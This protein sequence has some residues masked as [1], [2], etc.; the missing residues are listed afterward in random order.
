MI[1]IYTKHCFEVAIHKSRA[2]ALTKALRALDERYTPLLRAVFSAVPGGVRTLEHENSLLREWLPERQRRDRVLEA[3]TPKDDRDTI[4]FVALRDI[5]SLRTPFG[6][7]LSRKGAG[8]LIV[9]GFA[10]TAG[11]RAG[12]DSFRQSLSNSLAKH[13]GLKQEPRIASIGLGNSTFEHLSTK[14]NNTPD[15]PEDLAPALE[16][17]SDSQFRNTVIRARQAKDPTLENIAKSTGLD[18]AVVRRIVAKAVEG[19]VLTMK[20]NVLCP[21]CKNLLARVPSLPAIAQMEAHNVSCPS[22]G[23]SV[24][25]SSHAECYTVSDLIDPVLDSSKWMHMFF[26]RKLDPYLPAAKCVTS[27]L[28]GPNELDLI[29][30]VDGALLLAELKDNRFSIG[31]AYSFVGKCSQYKPEIA[32]IVATEG[33]EE[34]VKEYLANTGLRPHYI[35]KLSEIEASLSEILSQRCGARL[36]ELIA[37][38]SLDALVARSILSHLGI[39]AAPSAAHP[40]PYLRESVPSWAFE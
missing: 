38:L 8:Y 30:N 15:I 16:L 22:C 32:V 5:R 11:G 35:E 2:K 27:V 7:R 10:K 18:A 14:K 21:E 9:Y 13:L 37:G 4:A 34:E 29:A 28:D 6:K 36:A 17:L 26:R 3:Y 12:L 31:H 24:S 1:G 25:R 33:V 20:F 39:N 40:W 23:S 19:K